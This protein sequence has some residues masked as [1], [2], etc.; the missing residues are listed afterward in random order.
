M[1][2]MFQ[3]CKE[4]EY[5]DL[6]NFITD[7][8]TD[9]CWMFCGCYKLKEIKGVNNF[10]TILVNNMNSMFQY[11]QELEYLDLSNFNSFYPTDMSFMFNE[12]SKLKVINGINKF[13]NLKVINMKAMFQNCQELEYLDLSNFNAINVIDMSFM[14]QGCHKLK[15]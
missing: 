8:V 15:K 1:G 9:M 11:C 5:L 14:F 7:N 12:C 4:L 2:G 10:N 6:T 13:N 3:L